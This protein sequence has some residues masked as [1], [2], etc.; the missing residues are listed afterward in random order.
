MSHRQKTTNRWRQEL[1]TALELF[2]SGDDDGADIIFSGAMQ[3]LSP[4][5][6][7]MEQRAKSDEQDKTVLQAL[8][9]LYALAAWALGCRLSG[10]STALSA[11]PNCPRSDGIGQLWRFVVDVYTAQEDVGEDALKAY[12]GHI[13]IPAAR[14]ERAVR[15][16]RIL[17]TC[18]AHSCDH[19][20]A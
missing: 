10:R 2:W 20:L 1:L 15:I 4:L 5:I 7:S 13:L 11:P 14:G 8:R 16:V 6:T 3:Q 18:A 12:S 19:Q 17:Y 9:Y